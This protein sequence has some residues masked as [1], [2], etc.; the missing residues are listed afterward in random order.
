MREVRVL[1]DRRVV[2]ATREDNTRGDNVNTWMTCANT[3]LP[4]IQTDGCPGM[5][6]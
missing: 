5:R 3:L 4:L 1:I 6:L 2:C